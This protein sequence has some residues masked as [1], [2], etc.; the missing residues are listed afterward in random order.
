MPTEA[1]ALPP[2]PVPVGE[3]LDQLQAAGFAISP[4]VYQR[5][6]L[7]AEH[8]FPNG[9]PN[10]TTEATTRQLGE[11]LAPIVCRSQAEQAKFGAL[12]NGFFQPPTSIQEPPI[13]PEIPV[14]LTP[15][16]P[17]LVVGLVL[18]LAT[19]W[20][21][22]DYVTDPDS[23]K[24]DIR[25]EVK[26]TWP[27]RQSL[28]YA[29]DFGIKSV[30]GQ[31]ITFINRSPGV[32][33]QQQYVWHFGDGSDSVVSA[34]ATVSHVFKG[35]TGEADLGR[36]SIS[37]V[38]CANEPQHYIPSD[39]YQPSPVAYRWSAEQKAYSLSG[40]VP[41]LLL[42]LGGWAG[43]GGWRYW[44]RKRREKQAVRP[45]NGPFFLR[46]AP[47][48]DLIQP[49]PSLVN[50]A[51][52]LQQRQESEQY[53]LAI[54]ATIARTVR[55]GGMPT[56]VYEAVKRRPRYLVLIDIHSA[57][58]QQAQ[59]HAYLM[60][61]LTTRGVEMD[62]FFFHSDPRYAWNGQYPKGLPISDLRRLYST[63]YLILVTEGTRLL[64]YDTGGVMAWVVDA[65]GDWQNR[66]L[67]TPVFPA[68][69]HYLEVALSQ[70]FVLLPATPDGQ[71]LL[72]NFLEQPDET[73]TF[74][75]LMKQFGVLPGTPQR[76]IFGKTAKQLTL[77]DISLFLQQ[78]AATNTT[79]PNLPDRLLEWAC[80]TAVLP[81]PN[82]SVTLAIG[83][84]LE[85]MSG[86][87]GLV[88]STNLLRLTA[89]PW[90]RQ[91]TIP[92]PLRTNLLAQLPPEVA[93]AARQAVIDLLR[94]LEPEAGSLAYEEWQLRI[95][96][97]EYHTEKT[98]LRNLTAYASQVELVK[99]GQI[100]QQ[101]RRQEQI[102][103]RYV[104][105][106]LMLLVLT[107]LLLYLTPPQ[108]QV[109]SWAVP[110]YARKTVII[111]SALFYNNL[112]FRALIDNRQ[113][114]ES[115][116]DL[117]KL[118]LI[119]SLKQRPTFDAI[120]NLNA[121]RYNLAVFYYAMSLAKPDSVENWRLRSQS[122]LS[123]EGDYTK[124]EASFFVQK[125]LSLFS[126]YW[127]PDSTT[128]HGYLTL[129]TINA[130][131]DSLYTYLE[132]ANRKSANDQANQTLTIGQ[133][134]DRARF[135][136]QIGNARRAMQWPGS[137]QFSHADSITAIIR[138]FRPNQAQRD[139]LIG[140]ET[141]R[142]ILFAGGPH[143]S[144][145]VAVAMDPRLMKATSLPPVSL[146]Q[147]KVK[148][149]QSNYRSTQ[150]K[151]QPVQPITLP[152]S[153]ADLKVLM[154]KKQITI[155][156]DSVVREKGDYKQQVPPQQVQQRKPVDYQQVK[157][158][159]PPDIKTKKIDSLLTTPTPNEAPVIQK[160]ATKKS[161]KVS[162][163]LD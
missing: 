80:A 74:E 81:T 146:N 142:I 13:P 32:A 126:K 156:Q 7:V 77:N 111:D 1:T 12:F 163:T 38:G 88:A 112:A 9:L 151:A 158:Y 28:D 155:K 57:F 102:Q 52:Q 19:G 40:W 132:T 124:L 39:A 50:W 117:G 85:E 63:H 137:L 118:Q 62:V 45:Q 157:S 104:P 36:V 8:V 136:Q 160:R 128:M 161:S 35:S 89:L 60:G 76:G 3:L 95:W 154:P 51:Q 108:T 129:L 42:G 98:G 37:A 148:T 122:M 4:D 27:A 29:T 135:D 21:L 145:R 11:L 15:Q 101:L 87:D 123:P 86:K 100:R 2:R 115:R 141:D 127:V 67:L 64:D 22:V 131:T 46:F 94:T 10:P 55:M 47:Q 134:I 56:I 147:V 97:Q 49:S 83:K 30:D 96:E 79:D 70:F 59:L 34:K 139:S 24:P 120:Y 130:P 82:W 149:S 5:V 44:Q 61:V 143:R 18:V 144:E 150:V 26:K 106:A 121:N 66:A 33:N 71:V 20:W 25:K 65:L 133:P 153:G 140:L 110:F 119:R 116:Y 14:E 78:A 23:D 109:V 72:R 99:D 6:A 159:S 93:L 48:E 92:E 31:R 103:N 113:P 68:N 152:P 17:W 105:S 54:G 53:K 84:A 58:D 162:K 16:W 91:D 69:W 125:P 73:P 114:A 138:Q 75:A 41:L 90:L 107:P 43:Y